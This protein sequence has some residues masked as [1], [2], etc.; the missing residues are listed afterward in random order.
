[1]SAAAQQLA[2]STQEIDRQVEGSASLSAS[3][4]VEVGRASRTVETLSAAAAKIGDVIKLIDQIAGQTNLLALNATI[5]SARAGE[6]GK[7]FAVVA[8]EVKQLAAQTSRAIEEIRSQIE[9]IQSTTADAVSVIHGIGGIVAKVDQAN[10]A[11]ADAVAQQ[12]AAT[13]EIARNI[14]AVVTKIATIG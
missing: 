7:G 3:A 10:A 13:A 5:E 12:S 9:A 1:V 4:V 6:A 8:G 11:V 14:E 2:A